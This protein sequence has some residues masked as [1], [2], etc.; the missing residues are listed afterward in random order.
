MMRASLI[1]LAS[2]RKV[3][4]ISRVRTLANRLLQLLKVPTLC[5]ST[6][7]VRVVA[8][9][10]NLGAPPAVDGLLK[11]QAGGSRRHSAILR[12]ALLR[13]RKVGL[14][15]VRPIRGPP[16]SRI[17]ASV[18]GTFN[19]VQSAQHSFVVHV[20]EGVRNDLMSER[21]WVPVA[22]HHSEGRL[23]SGIF[24]LLPVAG[25]VVIAVAHVFIYEDVVAVADAAAVVQRCGHAQV[26]VTVHVV[27]MS[28][29]V[30]SVNT[31]APTY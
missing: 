22:H 17:L 4:Q 10:S 2:L 9:I 3:P 27:L 29:G 23:S 30:G 6:I 19:Q 7:G 8:G 14:K 12:V 31:C 1:R 24:D 11:T 15:E 13:R 16:L 20:R 25:D 18:Q 26:V 21:A 28:E 5:L